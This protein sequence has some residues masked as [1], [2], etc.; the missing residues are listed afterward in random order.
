[1]DGSHVVS[2]QAPAESL[3]EAR[4][5]QGQIF[6]WFDKVLSGSF[7][8]S[9]KRDLELVENSCVYTLPVTVWLM[10][11]QRLSGSGTL[12]SA[13]SDLIGG[14]G[15]ELLAPCKQVREDRISANTGAYSQA[16]QRMPVEA[17][18]RITQR[19][20]E[21][22]LEISAADDIGDRLFVLDGSSIRLAHSRRVIE[23]YPVAKNQLGD[24]HWPVLKVV[25]THHVR[26]GLA[27]AP[28]FGPMYGKRAVSEQSLAE[29]LID[30]LPASS[31]LIGDRNFGVFSVAWRAHQAGHSVIVRLTRARARRLAGGALAANADI[32]VRWK[33][34][35]D[36]LRAH[37]ELR[38]RGAHIEGRLVV[39]KLPHMDEPL[40]LFTTL[41]EPASQVV[42]LYAERWNI[43]T[44]LRSLKAQVKLETIAARSPGLIACE[45]LLAV[46][47]YNLIRMVMREAAAQINIDPRRLSFSRCRELVRAFTSTFAHC[48]DENQFEHTWRL[49]LRA[50]SQCQLPKRIRPPAPREVWPKP[51]SFPVRKNQTSKT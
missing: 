11:L 51:R 1:M 49:L 31:V 3:P 36:D 19:T 20:F 8:E 39:A 7:F 30:R 40:Y 5:R 46:A 17:A 13:V 9:L 23:R 45:L 33:P 32:K 2:Q 26:T 48:S 50:L 35:R 37:P 6:G 14:S 15:R 10:M 29:P 44:D 28:E 22:L 27:M 24:S 47:T 21:K 25:V 12:A 4:L 41:Q 38:G 16:R 42:A 18:W 43:E 34:S